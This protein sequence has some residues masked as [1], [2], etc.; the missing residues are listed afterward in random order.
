MTSKDDFPNQ[1][2]AEGLPN[3]EAAM[4]DVI[5]DIEI[6]RDR[7]RQQQVRAVSGYMVSE[8]GL[9]LKALDRA[10]LRLQKFSSSTTT[11]A[12]SAGRDDFS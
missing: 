7:I 12:D 2:P 4:R 6:A 9:I 10:L 3:D 8:F 5:R 11:P 1:Q